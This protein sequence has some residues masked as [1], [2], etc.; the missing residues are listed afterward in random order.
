SVLTRISTE[1]DLES[2]GSAYLMVWGRHHTQ[3]VAEELGAAWGV[4]LFV[5]G[6]Q[7]A[8]MGYETQGESMLIL[9]SD[10]EHGVALPIDLTRQD[11][12]ID[13]LIERLTP[14]AAVV[15]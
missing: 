13:T 10:H 1:A 3:K 11:D 6:H 5:M 2:H 14:L 7:P 9:A 8:E 15:L 12:T 4:R